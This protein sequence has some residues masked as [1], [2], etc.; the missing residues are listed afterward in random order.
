M[1]IVAQ[2]RALVYA[3]SGPAL[4]GL[5]RRVDTL[6][7]LYRQFPKIPGLDISALGFGF[8]RLPLLA[9]GQTIDEEASTALAQAALECGVNYFDTAWPYHGEKSEAFV[10]R[11]LKALNAREKTLVAT[12]SPVW[13]MEGEADWERYLDTQLERLQTDSIDFYLFHAING[14]SWEKIKSLKGLAAM[15]RALSDGRIKHLG[16]SFHGNLTEFKTI[17]DEYDWEFCQLQINYMDIKE[18]AGLEGLEYAGKKRVGVIAMEPLR[19]GALAANVPQEALDVFS[20]YKIPRMPAEWALRWVWNRPEI[21]C[22]LSGMNSLSQLV[23]NAGTASSQLPGLMRAE[24]T[25]I[26]D[27]AREAFSARIKVGCTGCRYCM[28]CPSGVDIPGTFFMYNHVSM[29]DNFQEPKKWYRDAILNPKHGADACIRC[30]ACE[31]KC[32]QGIAIMD[33]LAEA[34]GVLLS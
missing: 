13:K 32:P 24:E 8:M 3:N 30:G 33:K 26:V 29:Y 18:Q 11:A 19:G 14:Q 22:L 20:S 10:G 34:H 6:F 5:C 9:D 15:E 23:E 16:F 31:P 28:P 1:L 25:A 12:K 2:S 21:V 17:I 7:M 4:D 27:K